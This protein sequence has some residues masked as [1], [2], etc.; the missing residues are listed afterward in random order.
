MRARRA[1]A[2]AGPDD[3][4][5]EGDEDMEDGGEDGGDA[6]DQELY[7]YCQKLSYGEVRAACYLALAWARVLAG[8]CPVC[9]ASVVASSP[10]FCR[11]R[12]RRR[13]GGGG[14]GGRACTGEP[15]RRCR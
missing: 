12:R 6:E 8:G 2:S 14:G 13:R 10:V 7:C 4:D 5:A 15:V 11:R 3:E 1:H 9:P